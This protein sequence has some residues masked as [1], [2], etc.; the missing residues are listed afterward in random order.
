MDWKKIWRTFVENSV[1]LEIIY[2]A[3]SFSASQ[4]ACETRFRTKVKK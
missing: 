4:A 2:Y 3:N 1:K